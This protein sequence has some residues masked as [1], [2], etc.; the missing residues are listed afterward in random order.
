M[1]AQ[2]ERSPAPY[3]TP[4]DLRGALVDGGVLHLTAV[5]GVY[6]RSWRGSGCSAGSRS[7]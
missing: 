5:D 3:A 4:D 7:T 6:H 1:T 2:V